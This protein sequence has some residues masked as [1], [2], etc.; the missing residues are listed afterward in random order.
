MMFFFYYRFLEAAWSQIMGGGGGEQ[1]EKGV[2]HAAI[3]VS[4]GHLWYIYAL[5]N[6]ATL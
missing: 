6:M 1:G 5:L 3:F 2:I 4:P